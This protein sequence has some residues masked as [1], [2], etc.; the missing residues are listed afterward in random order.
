[1]K[2]QLEELEGTHATE[3]TKRADLEKKLQDSIQNLEDVK[4]LYNEAMSQLE[5]KK[6]DQ[7]KHATE[8]AQHRG[9]VANL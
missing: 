6:E 5:E 3:A 1:V 7:D 9:E 8:S 2:K 4:T